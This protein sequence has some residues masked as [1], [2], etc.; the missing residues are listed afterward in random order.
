M[1]GS[2]SYLEIGAADAAAS[3]RFFG[4][5]FGWPFHPTQVP[6]EGW[7]Q[8]AAMRIGLHGADP[9]PGIL[10]FFQVADMAL[11]VARVVELGGTAEAPGPAEEGFGTFCLCADPQGVP[12]GL[13]QLPAA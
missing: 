8:D 13:R 9:V 7:F 11:S 12:F 1:S 2:V 6:G 4:G 3:Q 5:L 10:V